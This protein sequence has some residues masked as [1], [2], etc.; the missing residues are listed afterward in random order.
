MGNLTLKII[1]FHQLEKW[2]QIAKKA[3]PNFEMVLDFR[4]S[5]ESWEFEY[6]FYFQPQLGAPDDISG[7]DFPI[8]HDDYQPASFFWGDFPG[9][10][11]NDFD[12]TL[13]VYPN[14]ES[15]S[16][17]QTQMKD[18]KLEKSSIEAQHTLVRDLIKITN[19]SFIPHSP[20]LIIH[21]P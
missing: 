16:R 10:Y 15:F 3:Y 7:H 21:P 14:Q 8:R 9:G 17:P 12:F 5:Q 19:S 20:S 2:Y 13:S 1:G 11:N 18:Y 6:T 4:K